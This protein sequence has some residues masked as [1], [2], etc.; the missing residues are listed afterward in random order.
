[1]R[2]IGVDKFDARE[3]LRSSCGWPVGSWA[4][5]REHVGLVRS[6]NWNG[7]E[8]DWANGKREFRSHS[9]MEEIWLEK[10]T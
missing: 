1:L 10:K 2:G 9:E 5:S 3:G 8:I 6:V 4:G 7:V